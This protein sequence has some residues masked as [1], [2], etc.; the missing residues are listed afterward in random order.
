MS[1]QIS[2][3]EPVTAV[4]AA[5]ETKVEA[6][7]LPKLAKGDA[8]YAVEIPGCW[9]GQMIIVATDD[10]EAT[11]RYTAYHGIHSYDKPAIVNKVETPDVCH[12]PRE[13]DQPA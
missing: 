1:E 13:S 6:V 8:F 4:D 2:T 7:A 5:V 11:D 9:S 12:L 10:Q 3:T